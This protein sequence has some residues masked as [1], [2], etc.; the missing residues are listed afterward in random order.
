MA[1][2][3]WIGMTGA[4]RSAA[5]SRTAAVKYA[6]V[7]TGSARRAMSRET[8][9]ITS[10]SRSAPASSHLATVV[11]VSINLSDLL[12]S[13]S[14]EATASTTRSAGGRAHRAATL[15]PS[16]NGSG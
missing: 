3:G 7:R 13:S 4:S 5:A 6:Q 9:G 10:S 11:L 8:V 2:A 16:S 15:P 12:G 1:S 14:G